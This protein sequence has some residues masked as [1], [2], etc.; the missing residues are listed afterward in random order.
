MA[1]DRGCT[2]G[3]LLSDL[4]RGSGPV[5]AAAAAGA[6]QMAKM[7]EAA[8]PASLGAE[9]PARAQAILGLLSGCLHLARLQPEPAL[10]DAILAA[11]RRAVEVLAAV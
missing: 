11:G 10:R 1:R 8:L 9:R 5:R 2:I 4:T 7:I 3:S 6:D